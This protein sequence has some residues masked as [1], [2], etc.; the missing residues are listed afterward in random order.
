ML[1]RN[2]GAPQASDGLASSAD[3]GSGRSSVDEQ[4]RWL[5]V[6]SL[7]AKALHRL[8]TL[9]HA[10]APA[11]EAAPAQVFSLYPLPPIGLYFPCVCGH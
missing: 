4:K 9:A 8:V 7:V 5:R 6:R 1:T 10:S 3:M 11:P 2:G